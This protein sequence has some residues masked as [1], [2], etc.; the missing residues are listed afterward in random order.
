MAK[1]RKARTA[2]QPAHIQSI[3]DALRKLDAK[4]LGVII[5]KAQKYQA[6]K[7]APQIKR[8]EAELKALN[9]LKK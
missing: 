3:L 7:V 8:L 4:E 1:E 5:T 2:K 9:A 6:G